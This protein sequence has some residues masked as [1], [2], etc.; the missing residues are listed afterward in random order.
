[1]ASEP[2]TAFTPDDRK[3]GRRVI[4]A[5]LVLSAIATPLVALFVGDHI[6]PGN[7][8]VQSEGQVF[9]NAV[10]TALLTPV[11]CL[12]VVYFGYALV[13]FRAQRNEALV[14][15]P[16]LRN[17]SRVQI[18]W[19]IVTTTTVLFLAGFGTYELLKDGSGGGQGPNPIALPANHK[20]AF[21]VQVIG[22]QWQFT[23]RYPSYGGMESNQLMLPAHRLIE[24]H[25]TSLDVVHSFWAV[26]LGLKAD[27]N[28]G[29]DNVV[30][31]ETKNPTT[32]H[33]RCAELC[34]LW[35]GYMFNNGRVVEQSQ[36][37]SW[38]A[39]EQK[40]YASIKPYVNKP[41]AQGGAPYSHTYLPAPQ[42]RAG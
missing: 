29:V 37:A 16:P 6:P 17:D 30:Y 13:R 40:T 31:V 38:A 3:H 5:W 20:T 18:I 41:E 26:E 23:Y 34:G 39:Q 27:A 19:M 36:F 22:Q 9:D 32:F 33:V 11:V 8:S 42:V 25:V 24:L 10:M 14:D 4:A 21:Q 12:M 15:G 35:H 2:A 7:A 1:M 28:P